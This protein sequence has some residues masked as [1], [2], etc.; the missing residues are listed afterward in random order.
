MCCELA[1]L[2]GKNLAHLVAPVRGLNKSVFL[3]FIHTEYFQ[4]VLSHDA[5]RISRLRCFLVEVCIHFSCYRIAIKRNCFISVY[6][7]R[8]TQVSTTQQSKQ[9]LLDEGFLKQHVEG[10]MGSPPHTLHRHGCPASPLPSLA[11][12]LTHSPRGKGAGDWRCESHLIGC[13]SSPLCTAKALLP[14]DSRSNS[15]RLCSAYQTAESAANA[16]L[17]SIIAPRT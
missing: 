9:L 4:V 17:K 11:C 12:T 5:L 14:A 3:R 1:C 10:R 15:A 13:S 16:K 2:S 6:P 8:L 7:S